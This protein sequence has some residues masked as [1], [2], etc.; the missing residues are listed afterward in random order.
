[1][2]LFTLRKMADGGIHDHLGGG[3]HRYSV[4]KRWHVPH[5][6]KM[7]YDQAQLVWSYL[8]AYQITHDEFYAEV[9]R[10]ILEYVKRDMMGA[11]GQF[12][13]AEDADSPLLD[14]PSRKAEG[15]FYL[16][17]AQEIE[18]IIGKESAEI[19]GFYYNVKK[20]G[21][22][23]R[24][25]DDEFQDKNILIISHTLDETAKKFGKS[26]EKV[27]KILAEARGKLF[28]ARE[29]RPRPHLDDKTLTAWNGLMISAFARASQILNEEEYLRV[30]ERATTFI[31]AKLY[32]N[33]S[34]KL[35]R[36]YRG[37]KS[38]IDGY[39]DDYA[40]FIQALI[41][42]YEASFD[43]AH[44][45]WAIEL[46]IK[47]NHLFGDADNGGFFNTTG[48]DSSVLLRMKDEYDGGVPSPNSVAALNL[49]RLGEMTGNKTFQ[50]WGEKL[51]T[52]F[53]SRLE[54]SPASMPQ[55]LVALG[56]KLNKPQQIVVA[57]KPDEADTR[58]MLVQIHKRFIPERILLLADGDEGQE[59][60]GA[61]LA[62]INEIKMLG[63]KATAYV[64]EDQVCKLPTTN[65]KELAQILDG[66]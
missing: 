9:A 13:S 44:L 24:N 40:Y 41:D 50:E 30:A 56:F 3:F 35:F 64:C 26:I 48:S 39:V 27:S 63:G 34:G 59:W 19:F 38:G 7:L 46:Q 58:A 17:K 31:H 33:A 18:A 57:G 15:V 47:Q 11:E 28:Q 45:Q 25:A 54:K 2:T 10:D 16:W 51:L 43:V 60:L 62:F 5:F 36:R 14:V 66:K 49:L 29:K 42:L 32:D 65:L 22:V 8:E 21:N 37:G 53:A 6:E 61:K 1:M 20:T 55:L 52:A 23:Q 12:Y 4:D